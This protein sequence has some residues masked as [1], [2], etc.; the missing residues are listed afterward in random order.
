MGPAEPVDVPG[1]TI[2]LS[3][4]PR[5]SGETAPRKRMGSSSYQLC[6]RVDDG[7]GNALGTT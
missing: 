1:M 6:K 3:L 5:R 7:P 2:E 4:M